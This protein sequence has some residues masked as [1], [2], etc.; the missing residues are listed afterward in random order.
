MNDNLQNDDGNRLDDKTIAEQVAAGKIECFK[1]LVQR[2]ERAVKSFGISFFR[3]IDDATDFAQ[4]VFIKV[5]NKLEQFKGEAKFSTWLYR[6]AYTTAINKANRRKE[7]QSLADTD[8][9]GQ[10]KTPEELHIREVVRLAVREAVAELPD[11]L[12]ICIDLF[13]F[14]EQSYEEINAITGFPVNTVKS[15][16]FR[17][18]KLLREKLRIFVEGGL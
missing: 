16:V 2:Y 15:H 18:K 6:V 11:K 17:A 14:Y 5:F 10:Y 8:Y 3:N 13:F 4:E 7:Y 9:E 12:R 1:I